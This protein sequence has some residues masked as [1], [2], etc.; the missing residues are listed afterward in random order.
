MT[1]AQNVMGQLD[2]NINRG[3]ELAKG[4]VIHCDTLSRVGYP[5]IITYITI[6]AAY[7]PLDGCEMNQLETQGKKGTDH[8]T[9][10]LAEGPSR[11]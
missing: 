6:T 7:I 4:N 8:R 11:A 1:D 3:K 10:D 5:S 9:A 2:R